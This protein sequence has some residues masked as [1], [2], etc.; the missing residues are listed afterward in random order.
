MNLNNTSCRQLLDM[1]TL[2]IWF[3]V[4]F[5]LGFCVFFF[6][7]LW[8]FVGCFC[9]CVLFGVYFGVYLFCLVLGFSVCLLG[10]GGF[11]VVW[12]GLVFSFLACFS[13]ECRLKADSSLGKFAERS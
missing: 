9:C 12:F 4:F 7:S 3:V 8:S 2:D 13:W 10:L 5:V 1:W 11:V 6:F